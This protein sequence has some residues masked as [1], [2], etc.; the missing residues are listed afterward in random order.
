MTTCIDLQIASDSENLPAEATLTQWAQ[1]AIG[2]A[3]DETE[4][5]IRIVDAEEGAEL[6]QTWRHK[7]GPTNVL[8]F[9]SDLPEELGLPLIGDLVICAPVVEREAWEQQKTLE[10]HWAHMVV[11]GTLHLL[12]YDHIEDTDA[13]EMEALETQVLTGL[14]Y[15]APYA[16][17]ELSPET[18]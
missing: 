12:G 6:N 11:H 18:T 17:D 13:L 10:A 4:I 14:G 15:P 7:Q 8:S 5:S 3:R 9:P 16:M 1:A 2:S